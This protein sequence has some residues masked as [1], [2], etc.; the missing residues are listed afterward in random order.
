MIVR[1]IIHATFRDNRTSCDRTV[2]ADLAAPAINTSLPLACN[3]Q[4]REQDRNKHNRWHVRV[5]IKEEQNYRIHRAMLGYIAMH[6]TP[7]TVYYRYRDRVVSFRQ[8][9]IR[10]VYF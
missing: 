4:I 6:A 5:L 7:L 10:P 3:L 8:A 9:H 2:C 1:E